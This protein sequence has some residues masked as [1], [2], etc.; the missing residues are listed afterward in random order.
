M[1]TSVT[2]AVVLLTQLPAALYSF[3]L[4]IAGVQPVVAG[5]GGAEGPGRRQPR[6]R[7]W[8]RNCGWA[9][10]LRVSGAVRWPTTHSGLQRSGGLRHISSDN[11][12]GMDGS[13]RWRHSAGQGSFFRHVY[14]DLLLPVSLSALAAG[15]LPGAPG[16]VILIATGVRLGYRQAKAGFVLQA[17]GIACFAGPGAVRCCSFGVIG[18][19]PSEGIARRPSGGVKR[20]MSSR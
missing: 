8:R 16:L 5:L 10:H 4:G 11:L 12:S 6:V 19:R 20:R 7:R 9:C 3:L 14:S 17:A 18:C 13:A 15:A 1:L 2:G